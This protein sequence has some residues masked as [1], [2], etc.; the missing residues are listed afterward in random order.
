[1]RKL[2]LY[3]ACSLDGYIAQPGDD[4]SFLDPFQVEGEDYGY[5]QFASQIDTVIM[6]RRTYDWLMEQVP[7]FP[8]KNWD[9]YI[10]TKTPRPAEGNIQFYTGSLP[11]LIEDIRSSP[12]KNIFCDGGAQVVNAF[13]KHELIDELIISVIPTLLGDGIRLFQEGRPTQNVE[14]LDQKAYANGLLQLHYRCQKDT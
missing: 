14:L 12:G 10:L 5:Q 7:E 6:G 8:H 3:I 4:L 11:K 1:M 9:A 2:I 13:L